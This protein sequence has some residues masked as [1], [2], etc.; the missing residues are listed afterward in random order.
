[1]SK[2]DDP[3]SPPHLSPKQIRGIVDRFKVTSG[4]AFKLADYPTRN[5]VPD[6]VDKPQ[7]EALLRQGVERLAE[8]QEL[9]YANGTWSLLVAFQAMDA[10]GKDSTIKHV[11]T[12]VN[13]AGIQV[14]SFKAPGPEELAHDFLWRTNRALPARGMLGIFNRSH[15]EEVLVTRVHPDILHRQR[16]PQ[17]LIDGKKFW[18]HRLEDIAAFER[19]LTRQ[20]TLVLK[21]FLNV[22]RD[23]QKKRFLSR[24]DEPDKTWKFS[25]D[26]INERAHWPEYMAAYEEAIRATATEHAPWFVVPADQKWFARLV[27]VAAIDHLIRDLDL[28]PPQ[29]AADVQA[30]F[31]EARAS[32]EAEDS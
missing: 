29:V 31:D 18:Q 15:Y 8:A 3:D 1:M 6:L 22:S 17:S 20:G 30:R 26:D 4:K 11:M 25:P 13:P 27:V 7:A 9:L 5:P 24:L 2:P 10:A 12:G 23:Q 14:T 21:V 32:L 28:K 19:H 16:L